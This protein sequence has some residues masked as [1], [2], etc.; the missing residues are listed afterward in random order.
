MSNNKKPIVMQEDAKGQKVRIMSAR[1]FGEQTKAIGASPQILPFGEVYS[2]LQTGVVDSAENPLSNLYNSKFYEVQSSVTMSNHGYL[3]YLVVLSDGFWK[4][5]PDDLK[6]VVKKA[7]KEAT[8]YEREL[9]AKDEAVLL[10][11]IEKYAKETGRTKVYYLDDAQKQK[12]QETMRAVYPKF[13]EIVGQELIE[14][15][16][17]TK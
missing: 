15:T 1:V 3:G 9:S 4:N 13:Y 8:D 12:W 7:L 11:N 6:E 16:L 14:K 17:A 5:L 2:A 10:A